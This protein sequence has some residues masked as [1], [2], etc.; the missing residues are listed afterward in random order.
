MSDYKGNLK[1][2]AVTHFLYLVNQMS[3]DQMF[4][5]TKDPQPLKAQFYPDAQNSRKF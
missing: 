5:R 1:L 2:L 4:F 3:V